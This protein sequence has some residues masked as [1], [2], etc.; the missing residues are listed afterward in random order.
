MLWA[1]KDWQSREGKN[2]LKWGRAEKRN[3]VAV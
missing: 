3:E 2:C 1:K